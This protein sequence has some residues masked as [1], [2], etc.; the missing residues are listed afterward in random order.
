[1]AEG[2]ASRHR[3]AATILGI[4]G[5]TTRH[6]DLDFR[7]RLCGGRILRHGIYD[8]GSGCESR[9]LQHLSSIHR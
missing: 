7:D 5:M 1:M 4:A 6:D 8:C 9:A 2:G 3:P